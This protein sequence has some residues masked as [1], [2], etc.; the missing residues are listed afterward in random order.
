MAPIDQILSRLTK[1]RQRQP[2]QWS[3]C[4]PAH[5]DKSPSLSVR[6]NPDGAVLINCL[7]GCDVH[8]VVA[9]LGLELSDLF[10]PREQPTGAPRRIPRLL[11]AGQALELLADEAN[12]VAVVAGN[13]GGGVTLSPDDTERVLMAAARINYLRE[14][15]GAHDA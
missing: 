2:G 13:I 14:R 8:D 1:V 10:P 3:A 4:C 15:T 7:A 12:F 6:E 5:A 11:T 9:A